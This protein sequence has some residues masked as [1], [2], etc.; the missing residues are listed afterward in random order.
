METTIPEIVE[1]VR[2][3]P[4]YNKSI[5]YVIVNQTEKGLEID[6]VASLER[7]EERRELGDRLRDIS[8]MDQYCAQ[9]IVF[10]QYTP[11]QY[12]DRKRQTNENRHTGL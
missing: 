5:Q 1:A 11:R 8:A 12:E 7:L 9:N 2:Y 10:H 6:V 4:V 3:I